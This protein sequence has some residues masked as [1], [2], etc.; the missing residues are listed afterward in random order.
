[1]GVQAVRLFSH[2]NTKNRFPSA[3]LALVHRATRQPHRL[4]LLKHLSNQTRSPGLFGLPNLINPDDFPTLA[5]SAIE[6]A[7]S[8]R[9]Y[10]SS[11]TYTIS[12]K[13]LYELDHISNT[14][15]S[16]I[17]AAELARCVHS[18]P[19]F[20]SKAEEA[21]QILAEFIATLNSDFTLYNKLQLVDED[22][23]LKQSFTEEETRMLFLL[24][25]EFEREG[26]HL[27]EEE[28][29]KVLQ[30]NGELSQIE[31]T[32]SS[33]IVTG[34]KQVSERSERSR[35]LRQL[36]CFGPS[37]NNSHFQNDTAWPN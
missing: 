16:V 19:E 24:K 25:A 12:S 28:R 7:N 29:N 32:F 4:P 5:Y 10:L 31:T 1:M 6:N 11:P 34:K 13:T 3:M 22:E 15:C 35:A 17:D 27:P 23:S 30:L 9:Q 21:F 26:I 37:L 8:M 2:K 14:V 36:A 18:S 33:N 20:R